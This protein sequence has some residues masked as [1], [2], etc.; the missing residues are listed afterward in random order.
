MDSAVGLALFLGSLVL[1][2]L[3]AII[4]GFLHSRRERLLT[5]TERMRALEM[6][7]P[8]PPRDASWAKAAVCVLIGV[9]VPVATFSLTAVAYSYNPLTPGPIWI[10]L[11]ARVHSIRAYPAVAD[12]RRMVARTA[13]AQL[14]FSPLLLAGTVVGLALTYLAPVA[15]A[16]FATG[17]AQFAGIFAWALMASVFRPILRFYGIFG[18]R[19]W[20][21]AAALPAIA[22]LY[23]AFTVDSAYQHARGRGGMWKGRAQANISEAQ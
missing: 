16:L 3:V 20:L 17:F 2:S 12:I 11:T 7:L 4:G 18:L 19:A 9:V 22:A 14:R 5:H 21:W 6:G 15:L 8:V 1:I 13:Y 23:M 10:G